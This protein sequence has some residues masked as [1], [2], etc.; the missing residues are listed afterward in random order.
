MVLLAHTCLS[1]QMGNRDGGREKILGQ[2]SAPPLPPKQ[3]RAPM[4]N[5]K[6][7]GMTPRFLPGWAPRDANPK[8]KFRNPS[9][10][11]MGFYMGFTRWALSCL[12]NPSIFPQ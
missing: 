12:E 7:V 1:P 8:G 10:S 3:L 2:E 5:S 11:K 6:A 4:R 9:Q